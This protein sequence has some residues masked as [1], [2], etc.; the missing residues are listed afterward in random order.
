MPGTKQQGKKGLLLLMVQRNTVHP[1]MG[2]MAV[3]MVGFKAVTEK[4]KGR[5]ACAE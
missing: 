1:G 5:N 3:G 4:Q 2:K